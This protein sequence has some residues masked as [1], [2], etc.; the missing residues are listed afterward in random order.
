MKLAK[1]PSERPLI[2]FHLESFTFENSCL[3]AYVIRNN[4]LTIFC[5]SV[6][7]ASRKPLTPNLTPRSDSVHRG[8]KRSL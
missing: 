2:I 7:D 1:Y 8:T 6:A 5:R 4:D 3:Q